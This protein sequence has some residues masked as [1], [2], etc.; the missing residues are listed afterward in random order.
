MDGGRKLLISKKTQVLT[1]AGFT[2]TSSDFQGTMKLMM[3]IIIA[4]HIAITNDRGSILE[5]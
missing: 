4:R 2:Y 5:S 1:Y 3:I